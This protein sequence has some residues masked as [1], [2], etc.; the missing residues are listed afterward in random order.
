MLGS[1][2]SLLC[3]IT[4]SYRQKRFGESSAMPEALQRESGPPKL[5]LGAHPGPPPDG[6]ATTR[7]HRSDRTAWGAASR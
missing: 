1:T 5:P 3:N 2:L 7:E 6:R 4:C